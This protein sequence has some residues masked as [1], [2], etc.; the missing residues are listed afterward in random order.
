MDWRYITARPVPERENWDKKIEFLLAVIG[1]AVDLGNVYRFPFI[2]YRN[3]GGAFLIPYV[4]MLIF[5]GLPLFYLELALGQYYKSGCITI[6][7]SLCPIMK[8]IGYAICFIDLYT[9][10]YYNTIIAWAFYYLFASLASLSTFELPWTKCNNT[11]NTAKCKTMEFR[12]SINGTNTDD[13][14]PA[15]EYFEYQVL[16]M[17]RST[18]IDSIGPIKLSLAFCL[19]MVFILVYF[20]LW[21]GVKSTGKVVWVTALMPYFVLFI[22]LIRGVTLDGSMDGIK[23]YLYPSWDRLYDINV[24]IDAAMQI[25]FSLG[26][27]FGT[28]MALSSYNK[29]HNNCYRD[30][31]LT[32]TINCLTSFMAGFVIFSVLGYM[33]KKMAKD[34]SEVAAGG[35][36]LVFI[37]YPEAI[38]EMH[39]S[40]FWSILFFVMLI[41]LGLDSTFGGLEAMI[42]GLCD[43]FPALLRRN[44]EIFVAFIV[45][46]IY[47]CA[48]PT[49]T[50]GGKYVLELL[51]NYGISLPLLFVVFI[52][53]IAVCWCYGSEKF[54]CQIEEMLGTKPGI[55]W[56]ICWKFI[57]PLFLGFIFFAALFEYK[58]LV[59]GSYVYP[60]WSILLGWT[61]TLSSMTCIPLY[62]IYKYLSLSGRPIERFV[63]SFKPELDVSTG[64]YG[65]RPGGA[66]TSGADTAHGVQQQ[67]NEINKSIKSIIS[68]V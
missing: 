35:P 12:R 53:T 22:L 44:R 55:F 38:A 28:L 13:V 6:W 36:G 29:F 21:K 58:D 24:W 20:S 15:Q 45:I 60:N 27:G 64:S 48:I 41:T 66:A 39:G 47:L 37:V 9:G 14:S 56:R 2:C 11:W 62:A 10:M 49:T 63:K 67:Q 3:G 16:E 32:S 31:I 5:G 46:F 68:H 26:P 57:S 1:F 33:A 50:Y 65:G 25:F 51:E 4:V 54:S 52:E 61:I 43:E 19:M 17:H 8:G 30:A 40:V 59:I 18:G 7:K 23:Y 34:I 42:T